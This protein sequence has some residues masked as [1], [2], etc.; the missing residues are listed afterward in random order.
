MS[1]SAT[2]FAQ[3]AQEQ[4]LRSIHQTQETVVE[5]VRAWASAVEKSLPDTPAL[6]F[7]ENL[8]SP[9]EIVKTSF[10]FAER[11]LRVQRDFFESLVAAAAPVIEPKSPG[12]KT[13]PTSTS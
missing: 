6:P 13:T 4:T 2:D 10:D 9:A 11:L 1:A 7:L 8:P 3:S 12:K 5:A